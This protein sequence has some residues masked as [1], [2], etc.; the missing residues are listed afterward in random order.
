MPV[1][2]RPIS[3]P[4]CLGKLMESVILARLSRSAD[5]TL[6]PEKFGLRKSL[7]TVQQLARVCEHVAAA[8]L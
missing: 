3:L 1:N 5:Y 8:L 4:P 7:V 2:Y 6:K